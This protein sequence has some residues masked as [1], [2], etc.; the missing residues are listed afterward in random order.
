[1]KYA[2][3]GQV[4]TKVRHDRSPAGR[5]HGWQPRH[6][7]GFVATGRGED[8]LMPGAPG[9]LTLTSTAGRSAEASLSTQPGAF[10]LV[11]DGICVRPRRRPYHPDYAAPF[12]FTGGVIDKGGG[13]R[14]R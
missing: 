5:G 6:H 3:N 12:D 10:C 13:R 9:T 7:R 2:F 14:L 1:M 4:G 8:P 11:G